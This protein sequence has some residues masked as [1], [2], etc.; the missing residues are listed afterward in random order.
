MLHSGYAN[1]IIGNGT[2]FTPVT[3]KHSDH[4]HSTTHSQH[5][6][7]TFSHLSRG[8]P[9]LI[10]VLNRIYGE[11]LSKHNY[12]R[13]V[14]SLAFV[15]TIIGMITFGYLMDR[16]GRKSG[17]VSLCVLYLITVHF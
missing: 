14:T 13:T 5:L 1:G 8:L 12:S 7:V 2:R 6:Y 15:G 3:R 11:E 17:M 10:T 9:T 16:I 4:L